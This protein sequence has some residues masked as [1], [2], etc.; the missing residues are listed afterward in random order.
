M[1]LLNVRKSR[2]LD[3]RKMRLFK[4]RNIYTSIGSLCFNFSVVQC[5][6]CRSR[7]RYIYKDGEKNKET[8]LSSVQ[9]CYVITR[10]SGDFIY[11]KYMYRKS[12]FRFFHIYI[13]I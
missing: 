8:I 7:A 10:S 6:I 5:S 1:L 12:V 4:L 2:L 13:Y 11:L 3:V 9:A